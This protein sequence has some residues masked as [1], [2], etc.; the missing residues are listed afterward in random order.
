VDAAL[1][2]LAHTVF[3]HQPVTEKSSLLNYLTRSGV[4]AESMLFATLDPTTR[5]VKLPGLKTHPEVLLTDTVGFIQKLPT[6]LVAAFRA[7]LEEVRQADVLVH[8]IDVSNPTWEKQEHSVKSVLADLGV[9]NKPIVRV[10][11]KIDLLDAEDAEFL[12]YEA[13]MSDELTVAVSALKG[14]GMHDFVAVVEE[15]MA[16]L[17]VPIEVIIPYSK[18]DEMNV[19]HEQ[20]NVEVVDYRE[21]GTY[22]KALVPSAVANRLAQYSVMPPPPA[23]AKP[24]RNARTG[25]GDEI[26]WVAIGRGRHSASN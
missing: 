21:I 23:A 17:L 8:V 24:K 15:A 5:K 9:S 26:D 14:E 22:V 12:R 16:E 3:C 20:G 1:N 25:D 18:G 6:H 4:L 2:V 13:A 7:T 19:I 11:N 10:L